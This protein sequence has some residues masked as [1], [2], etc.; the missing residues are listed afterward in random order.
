MAIWFAISVSW[1]RG[2]ALRIQPVDKDSSG[3]ALKSG[4]AT[5]ASGRPRGIRQDRHFLFVGAPFGPFSRRLGE[6]LR[7]EGALCTRIILNAGD[8][9]DWGRAGARH[10]RGRLSA[11]PAWLAYYLSRERVTDL[12]VYGDSNPYCVAA[13]DRARRTGVK[14]HVLEQGYFRPHWITLERDGVNGSSTMPRDPRFFL[15]MARL[16]PD[17]PHVEVGRIARPAVGRIL[18]YHFWAYLGCLAF[19]NFHFAY[20]DP[21]LR[22][23]LGHVRRYALQRLRSGRA[24]AVIRRI[25]ADPAPTFLALQQ[26]PGD[27]QLTRHSPLK[28]VGAFIETVLSS[29]ARGAAPDARLVFKCHPLDPGLE[30]HRGVIRRLARALGVEGRVFYV[31]GG[32]LAALVSAS[33]GVISVNS[34]ASLVGLELGRPTLVLGTAVYDIQGLTHQGGLETFWRAPEAPDGELFAAYCRVVM[35][36]TQINGA[37]STAHGVDLALLETADRLLGA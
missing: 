32:D 34:T 28:S 18:T 1:Q 7:A 17:T 5:L 31:D 2:V 4:P 8:A 6:A 33:A 10:Y 9:M 30:D 35:A 12:I 11:W 29:F 3:S 19:P 37:Y 27:S 24:G 22:Q 16:I 21:P 20:Q 13:M 36:N 14:V 23:A 25:A 26:R 15:Q